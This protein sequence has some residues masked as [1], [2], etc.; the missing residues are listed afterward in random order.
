MGKDAEETLVSTS[1]SS[2]DKE[3]YKSV[4]TKFDAF[5]V[6]KNVILD[7]INIAKVQT[8]QSNS[9]FLVFTPCQRTVP[10]GA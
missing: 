2:E 5:S 6:R 9:S 8:S 4:I 7:S 3:K 10:T 1:T